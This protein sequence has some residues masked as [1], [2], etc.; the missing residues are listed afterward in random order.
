[1]A[2]CVADLLCLLT[3]ALKRADARRSLTVRVPPLSRIQGRDGGG[4]FASRLS[5]ILLSR[6]YTERRLRSS[7]TASASA[8]WLCL[9]HP[10]RRARCAEISATRNAL[11]D[12]LPKLVGVCAS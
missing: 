4:S 6:V 2:C 1:M 12:L 3:L 5:G 7:P 10:K 11:Y 9:G 8:I